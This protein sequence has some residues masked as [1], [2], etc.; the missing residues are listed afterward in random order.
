MK[1]TEFLKKKHHAIVVTNKEQ[2]E[3]VCKAFRENGIMEKKTNWLLSGDP[4]KEMN[5][6][7]TF[8][9]YDTAYWSSGFI[10]HKLECAYTIPFNQIEF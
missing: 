7:N 9:Y 4:G 5:V 6:K 10:S 1:F 3:M 2:A 8:L